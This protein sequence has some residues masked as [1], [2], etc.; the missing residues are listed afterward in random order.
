DGAAQPFTPRQR[1]AFSAQV[2][3]IYDGFI[4]RVATGRRL[5]PDRVREIAKGRVWTGAQAKPLG[6]VDEV[7]GFYAAVDKAKTLAGLSGQSVHLKPVAAHRS[8]FEA[9]ERALGAGSAS[10]RTLMTAIQV[11]SDPRAA[12][13]ADQF[14]QARLQA[15]GANLIAPVQLP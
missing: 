1:A 13:L 9:L 15:R 5:P 6:L 14:N 4:T 3:K 8:P 7:G 2:D 11:L 12:A 10:M